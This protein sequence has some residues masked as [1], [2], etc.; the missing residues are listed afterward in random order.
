MPPLIYKNNTHNMNSKTP[1]NVKLVQELKPIDYPTRF[2]FAKW[3][4]MD[5]QKMPILAKKI[6]F[7]NEANF[8]LGGCVNKQNCRIGGIENPHACIEKP[9]HS[10]RVTVWCG[11]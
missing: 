1:Y 6:I 11:F 2:P 4:A 5:L 3:A 10:K 8:D 9:T 7:S